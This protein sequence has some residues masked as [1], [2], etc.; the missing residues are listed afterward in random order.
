MI[1]FE[2]GQ[3]RLIDVTKSRDLLPITVDY[4]RANTSKGL[5]Q[6]RIQ[7][8]EY[9]Q[10]ARSRLPAD[11]MCSTGKKSTICIESQS[12]E[13]QSFSKNSSN[14]QKRLEKLYR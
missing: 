12:R 4:L 11:C 10:R 14:W 7:L 1:E 3:K 8:T 6:N 2:N 13:L 9:V 5:Y